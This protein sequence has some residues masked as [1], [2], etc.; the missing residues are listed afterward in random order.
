MEDVKNRLS[1]QF[2]VKDL[3]DLQYILG[4]SIIQNRKEKSVWIGLVNQPRDVWS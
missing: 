1:A 4:V 2:E 3:G